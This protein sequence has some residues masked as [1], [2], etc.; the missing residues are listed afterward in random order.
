MTPLETTPAGDIEWAIAEPNASAAAE[1]AAALGV[2]PL[3]GQLLLNRKVTDPVAGA[4]YLNPCLDE[5]FDPGDLPDMEALEGVR[6]FSVRVKCATL[7]WTT[8]KN[9][10]VE[11]QAGR[12]GGETE[13]RC[14]I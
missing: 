9:G 10:I 3:T 7:S 11:Y 2:L 12:A 13:E 6:K 14:D 5:L 8:L 1:L 4:R